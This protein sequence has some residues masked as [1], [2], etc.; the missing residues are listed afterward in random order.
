MQAPKSR[1]IHTVSYATRRNRHDALVINYS[2]L[3]HRQICDVV[4]AAPISLRLSR[5]QSTQLLP[6]RY[7]QQKGSI[8]VSGTNFTAYVAYFLFSLSATR[9]AIHFAFHNP[10]WSPNFQM[11]D[12]FDLPTEIRLQIL[13]YM[14]S[15]NV[16]FVGQ[17]PFTKASHI[18]PQRQYQMPLVLLVSKNFVDR[19]ELYRAM[20]QASSVKLHTPADVY[21]IA[22]SLR[23]SVLPYVRTIILPRKTPN[24]GRGFDP[25]LRQIKSLLPQLKHII[26]HDRLEPFLS[27]FD[28]RGLLFLAKRTSTGRDEGQVTNVRPMLYS[29]YE[30]D[31][32]NKADA[33]T[34]VSRSLLYHAPSTTPLEKWRLGLLADALSSDVV[35]STSTEIRIEVRGIGHRGRYERKV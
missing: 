2:E 32:V 26:L 6:G 16:C 29:G 28:D 12:W 19:D 14:F 4:C 15:K 8:Q 35:V 30:L 22:N 18:I 9:L 3:S 11:A 20:L 25:S 34:I 24:L 5:H 17:S 23:P 27:L 31:L 21:K 1:L 10:P 13:E 7:R 33:E